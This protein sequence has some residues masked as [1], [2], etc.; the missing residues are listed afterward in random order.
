[1]IRAPDR[2]LIPIR[3]AIENEHLYVCHKGF[4]AISVGHMQCRDVVYDIVVKWY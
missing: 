1:V 4:H 2:T 3:T